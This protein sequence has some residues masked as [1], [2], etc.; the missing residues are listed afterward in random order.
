VDLTTDTKVGNGSKLRKH[1]QELRRR[2]ERVYGYK[3]IETFIVETSEGGGVLHMVWAWE[4][5]R[6]FYIPQAWLSEEWERI[7]GAPVAWI[8]K[9]GG[10]RKDQKCVSKYLVTQYLADQS[11]ALVR[12][13][14]S[15]Y[16]SK[17]A[18]GKAWESL[19]RLSSVTS[20]AAERWDGRTWERYYVV[21]MAEMVAAW[22]SL[23]ET[24]EAMLGESLII[25]RGRDV[26][27]AF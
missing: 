26:V 24:G 18:I 17:V 25:L 6:S 1:L 14:Y 22:Q 27:E 3:G 13:T 7:H 11:G 19:K 20:R 16:R 5:S 4:G 10:S 2:V 9:M 23:L 21:P 12:V 15:W 8:A